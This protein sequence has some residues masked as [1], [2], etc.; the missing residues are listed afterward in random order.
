MLFAY[1]KI[2]IPIVAFALIAYSGGILYWSGS[3]LA[4]VMVGAPPECLLLHPL[5]LNFGEIGP[6]MPCMSQ[7][8]IFFGLEGNPMHGMSS[9]VMYR[10]CAF[11]LWQ[12]VSIFML[13]ESQPLTSKGLGRREPAPQP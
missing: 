7:G 4:G 13:A 10:L 12:L 1:F 8:A 6:R 3:R 11:Y 5:W 2:Y 9:L